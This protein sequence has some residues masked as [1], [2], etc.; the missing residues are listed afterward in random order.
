[1]T[2]P[3]DDALLESAAAVL[4]SAGVAA[5]SRVCCALSGGI[6]SVVLFEVLLRL[7]PRFGFGLSAAH[8]DHGLSPNADAWAQACAR[9][10]AQAGIP[11]Q[12]FRVEVDR[13]HADGL[14]AA[15]RTARR[16]ALERVTCDWLAFG[17]HQDDQAETLLFRLLRGSG[18]RGVAAMRPVVPGAGGLP[19][20]LRPLLAVRR[21]RVRA[22]A[23][24]HAL[25]WV[26]DESNAD[27]RFT[28]N[29]IR[30]RLLPVAEDLFPAAVLALAR[31][32]THFGAADELLGELAALDL[33]AC[34]GEPLRRAAL[35]A[36]SLS[37]QANLLRW[38]LLR[39]GVPLPS[40]ARIG[41]ALRQLRT[42]DAGHPLRLVLG[43]WACCAY[44]DQVWLE[45]A[46]PPALA[47]QRWQGEP[48]LRWGA[49]EVRFT[50][51]RGAGLDRA[52]LDRVVDF[53]VAP[54]VAGM[55]LRLHPARPRRALRKL[56]QEAEIPE[57]LRDRLPVLWAD[58]EPVWV[59]GIGVVAEFACATD[60]SGVLPAWRP[61]APAWPSAASP[62]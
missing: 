32:A 24:A 40:T 60:A 21:A 45:P 55:R 46:L 59:G 54:R 12:I 6:D 42:C 31:A 43:A 23:H 19:G 41:E 7:Q 17:H 13:D 4:A 2:L 35:L 37:R 51:T 11:L 47:A 5:H 49:G 62:G 39:Q 61:G 26:E 29:A 18:V 28:R 20:R 30:H 50:D 16:A 57:W 22:W 1:M 38:L 56:C 33:L 58:G 44:R 15:A 48:V 14:E 36:L 27:L 3:H 52:R 10:C 53:V 25:E 34:G 8:V 9:R